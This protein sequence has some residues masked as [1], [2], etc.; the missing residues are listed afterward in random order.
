[1]NQELTQDPMPV[2]VPWKFWG[3]LIGGMAGVLAL[4]ILAGRLIDEGRPAGQL[5]S[6]AT[7]V[8]ELTATNRDGN[9]VKF[10]AL[11]GKVFT[12][13]YLYT[14]CPHGCAAVVGQMMKLQ[15]AYGP[16]PDFHQVSV[17]VAP[18]HDTPSFLNTYA[19]GLG[20]R[21]G[22]PWWF[23]TGDQRRL[24]SFMDNE[25]KLT[26][27]KPIP[28]DERL[29]PLDLY[30]HDLR[31]VLIDRQGR[32]RGYY[33][34]FHAQSEIAQLMSDKLQRDVRTLLDHPEL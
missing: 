15:R 13:A 11:R 1:M 21:P 18:E 25:L 17:T 3:A 7:I 14:V 8:G 30:Q 6:Y 22:D 10:S 23:V 20:L 16:R 26:S 12:C 24:W 32:V 5:P 33:E 19:E 31:I 29:N 9:D 28:P 4:L 2:F 34:V 27:A